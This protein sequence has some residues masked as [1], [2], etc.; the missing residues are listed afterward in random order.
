M[1]P[2]NVGRN[3]SM[4]LSGDALVPVAKLID[5]V[6]LLKQLPAKCILISSDWKCEGCE[7]GYRLDKVNNLCVANL[8]ND[9]N[10]SITTNAINSTSTAIN[11]SINTPNP[12]HQNHTNSGA[13]GSSASKTSQAN[14]FLINSGNIFNPISSQNISQLPKQ[15]AIIDI[16]CITANPSF[17]Y[18]SAISSSNARCLQCFDK[19]YY[20]L[21]QELCIP[22]NP[23]CKAINPLN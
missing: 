18:S 10:N 17:S 15:S 13:N 22:C 9:T 1:N 11:Q 12:N 7:N 2:T 21:T 23:L 14:S 6:Q 5:I 3:E 20:N 8:K 16:N 4:D 19:Y